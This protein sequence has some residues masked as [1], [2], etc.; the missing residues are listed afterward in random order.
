MILYNTNNE[1][2]SYLVNAS[3][4]VMF[5]SPI[6]IWFFQL[7]SDEGVSFTDVAWLKML[8]TLLY[9][10]GAHKPFANKDVIPFFDVDLQSIQTHMNERFPHY[11]WLFAYDDCK[12]TF[13][14]VSSDNNR[15]ECPLIVF[16]RTLFTYFSRTFP[17]VDLESLEFNLLMIPPERTSERDT[18]EAMIAWLKGRDSLDLIGKN[19]DDEEMRRAVQEAEEQESDDSKGKDDL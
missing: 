2:T 3:N 14:F 19:D 13:H 7:F 16:L 18:H 8:K 6:F 15:D 1:A 5:Q 9:N 12:T 17:F 4:N 11:N 10:E